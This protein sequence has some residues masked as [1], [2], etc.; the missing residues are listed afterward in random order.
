MAVTNN[1]KVFKDSAWLGWQMEANW[2]DPFLFLTYSIVKPIAGTLILVL[3]YI[4]VTGGETANAFFSYMYV[5]NAMYMF[6]AEVLFGVTWV[7]HD[8]RE[9]YMTL[10]QV[11]IAPMN[12]YM[13]I[14]GRS[15]IKIAITSFG[16]FITI[17]F[18]VVALDVAIDLTSIDW[19]LLALSLVLGL[20]SICILGLALGGVSFLTAK[21]SI[22]I[23]E[24]LAGVFYVLSGVVFPITILPTWAE[25]IS[26]FLPVT[27]WMEAVR[28]G[29]EPGVMRELADTSGY[30]VTG[31]S[32][33][34]DLT[35][36]L[37]LL[38]SV[39]VFFALSI[40]VFRIA[41]YIARKKGKIDW[42]TAY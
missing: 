15:A 28:R 3:M 18:G 9:H 21:H 27:Y 12:F 16:V 34:S 7:I 29:M 22:G 30:D 36:M 17:L 39:G 14:M 8:D 23:N 5:G 19:P 11:Y 26:R 25:S 10:K 20:A 2:T 42:T 41:D 4:V 13:Y 37:Y 33:V 1:L 31:M 35:I 24:G 38:I 40:G 32:N 6:V